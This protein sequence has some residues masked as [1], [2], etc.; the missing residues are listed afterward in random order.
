MLRGSGRSGGFPARESQG[1]GRK[2]IVERRCGPV[3]NEAGI[4]RRGLL[5]C[6]SRSWVN[7]TWSR[8]SGGLRGRASGTDQARRRA[9]ECASPFADEEAGGSSGPA[10][11]ELAGEGGR[12]GLRVE[13][14]AQARVRGSPRVTEGDL[15][16]GGRSRG[17]VFGS[18]RGSASRVGGMSG[19]RIHCAPRALGSVGAWRVNGP[20]RVRAVG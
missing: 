9:F 16:S 4:R 3:S 18:G 20:G 15:G 6:D 5:T 17:R 13:A 8:R 2:A 1:R 7:L 14:S 10:A 12:R 11:A 19:S